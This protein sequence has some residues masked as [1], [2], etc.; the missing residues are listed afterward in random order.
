MAGTAPH[1]PPDGTSVLAEL[2]QSHAVIVLLALLGDGA[3]A[4]ARVSSTHAEGARLAA[5]IAELQALP[6]AA[7]AAWMGSLLRQVLSPLPA[8]LEEL[9][10]RWLAGRLAELPPP[11]QQ[12]LTV[13][14]PPSL[15]DRV[16]GKL[17]GRA[18]GPAVI[19]GGDPGATSAALAWLLEGA[20]AS[21]PDLPAGTGSSPAAR[22]AP[23]WAAADGE[24]LAGLL[25]GAGLLHLSELAGPLDD[26]AR[27]TLLADLGPEL[28]AE[29][30]RDPAPA[31]AQTPTA[32][33]V[34][35]AEMRL[36]E[37]AGWRELPGD[38]ATRWGVL[39]LVSSARQHGDLISRLAGRLPPALGRPLLE[40]GRT[41]ATDPG[42]WPLLLDERARHRRH[43]DLLAARASERS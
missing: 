35:V 20:T 18:S 14:L 8:G 27:A 29:L 11:L 9:D 21:V 38:L 30:G 43:L 4:S 22:S 28:A 32:A 42:A 3:E 33:R 1:Q 39:C 12:A 41:A 37:S 16:V 23:A 10:P 15:L 36:L 26:A 24:A 2:P 7:R 17:A 25:H 6:R 31:P 40:L 5:A 13:G 19:V 34:L